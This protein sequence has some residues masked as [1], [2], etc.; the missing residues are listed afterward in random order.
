MLGNLFGGGGGSGPEPKVATKVFFDIEIGGVPAGQIKIGLYDAD[1]PK[2]AENFK[3][4][5]TGEKGFGYE[6]PPYVPTDCLP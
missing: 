4:L 3:A 5:C 6:V 2:T 1:V